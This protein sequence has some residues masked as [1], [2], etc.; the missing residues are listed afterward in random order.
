[1]TVTNSTMITHFNDEPSPR[2]FRTGGCREVWATFLLF[3]ERKVRARPQRNGWDTDVQRTRTKTRL[4]TKVTQKVMKTGRITRND[5]IKNQSTWPPLS[6]V[7]RQA[8]N[9]WC[10]RTVYGTKRN[11]RTTIILTKMLSSEINLME[12]EIQRKIIKGNLKNR[13]QNP[14]HTVIIDLTRVDKKTKKNSKKK[15]IVK[16]T[17]D[18]LRLIDQLWHLSGLQ[19]QECENPLFRREHKKN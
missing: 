13:S 4:T 10:T 18:G 15:N 2:D 1:M 12:N 6:K 14:Q 19:N 8:R 5:T 17:N 9:R 3:L 11:W 7:A 16:K